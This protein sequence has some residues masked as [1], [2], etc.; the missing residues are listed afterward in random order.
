MHL[1]AVEDDVKF[2][3]VFKALVQRFD[4]HLKY[5]IMGAHTWNVI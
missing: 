2:A 4:K 1:I 3:D 5:D